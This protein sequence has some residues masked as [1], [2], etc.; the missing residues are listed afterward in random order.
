MSRIGQHTVLSNDTVLGQDVTI[1]NNVTIYPG[2]TIGDGSTIMDGA[3]LGRKPATT[4]NTTR[5]VNG[6]L[7]P[8]VIGAHCFIGVNAVVYCG[9]TVADHVLIGDL[10]A[11]RE[12]CQLEEQVVV[13]RG[14]LIMYETRVGAR[15]RVI[16]GAILT[17]NMTIEEDVFIG[18]G[19][20]SINDNEVYLRRFGLKPFVTQ[21]PTIRRFAV[22]GAGANLNSGVEIGVGAIVAPSAMV[23]RDVAAWT[24]VAGVPA[25]QVRAVDDESRRLILE[26]FGL[27]PDFGV[28]P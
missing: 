19:A 13:G 16:D 8:L 12:G 27:P 26:K 22:I 11:I 3:V 18:P 23:T 24:I 2:V 1:G 9:T 15:S 14:V 21:G 17:G 20:N 25:I 5:P 28:K 7:H 4:G 10:A 6:E